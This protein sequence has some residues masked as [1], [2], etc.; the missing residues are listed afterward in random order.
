MRALSGIFALLLAIFASSQVVPRGEVGDSEVGALQERYQY[1]L[2]SIAADVTEH[3]FP[4]HFY[5]SRRLD[6]DERRLRHKHE[7][8]VHFALFRGQVVLAVTGNYYAAYYARVVNKE[9][10][11]DR[12]FRDAMFPILAAA[13]EH[14]QGKAEFDG[15]ALEISH[16]IV[17]DVLGVTMEA[18]EN[19]LV[20]LPRRAAERLIAAPTLNEQQAAVSEGSVFVNAEPIALQLGEVTIR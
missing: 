6:V 17:G 15:Y 16:H 11:A 19:L 14:L 1:E 13:V 8:S 3:H 5:L 18:P 10:R 2:N 12:T 4:Y 7:N 9:R 20:L